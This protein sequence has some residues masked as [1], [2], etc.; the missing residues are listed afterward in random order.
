[1]PAVY[2]NPGLVNI[3][4]MPQMGAHSVPSTEKP[5]G[6]DEPGVPTIAPA[7]ANA[8]AAATGQRIRKPPSKLG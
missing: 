6:V 3:D 8:L 1:M 2:F 5:A 7:V 4:A